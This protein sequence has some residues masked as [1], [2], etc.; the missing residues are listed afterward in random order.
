MKL[1][2]G[3][4]GFT[5]PHTLYR[6]IETRSQ[7]YSSSLCFRQTSEFVGVP[8]M[9]EHLHRRLESVRVTLNATVW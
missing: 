1:V 2:E 3:Q 5:T 9:F 8:R 4:R 6:W 7:L